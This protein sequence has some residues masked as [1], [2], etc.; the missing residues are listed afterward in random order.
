LQNE[1]QLK[2]DKIHD[3]TI[4]LVKSLEDVNLLNDTDT[5]GHIKRVSKISGVL[6]LGYYN[7]IELARVNLLTMNLNR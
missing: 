2:T 1:L 4:A 3:I 6:A 5:G 7:D